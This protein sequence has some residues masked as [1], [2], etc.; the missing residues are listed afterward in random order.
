MPQRC[1][2]TLT[3]A[4]HHRMHA[5]RRRQLAGPG[6][7]PLVAR[8]DASW[9]PTELSTELCTELIAGSILS[10]LLEVEGQ[11]RLFATAEV[12]SCHGAICPTLLGANGR[13]TWNVL[14]NCLATPQAILT[15]AHA[16]QVWLRFHAL[17]SPAL[18]LDFRIHSGNLPVDQGW[19]DT[20]EAG[21]RC[22]C[23]VQPRPEKP[24]HCA[25]CA[26]VFSVAEGVLSEASRL[27]ILVAARLWPTA[28]HH[29]GWRRLLSALTGLWLKLLLPSL[30]LMCQFRC[31]L[32]LK[33][34]SSRSRARLFWSSCLARRR[35]T[36]CG[37]PSNSTPPHEA[38]TLPVLS[39]TACRSGPSMPC[40]G[41][42]S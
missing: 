23:S 13:Q 5:P 8:P 37:V 4:L 31:R 12:A 1:N 29:P 2:S 10:S 28:V 17:Q 22:H 24:G 14:G 6:C 15:L 27:P 42:S 11:V 3:Q 20:C 33:R 16:L 19:M 25:H 18:V 39:L 21:R 35:I 38:R 41:T 36:T 32:F 30:R 9:Q 40:P 34:R 7:V 26:L